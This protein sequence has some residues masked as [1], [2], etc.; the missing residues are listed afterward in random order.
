MNDQHLD[1]ERKMARERKPGFLSGAA[2]LLRLVGSCGPNWLRH[3][4]LPYRAAY[5]LGRHAP[6]YCGLYV[7]FRCNLSCPWCVNP[8]L[9][10]GLS[11]DDYEA[12]VA[13]VIRLLDHPLFRSVAHINLTGG[14]PLMNRH[15]PGI[16]RLIRQ[17]GFLVGMVTN[18]LLLEE[19]LTE[20]LDAGVADVRVSIYPNTVDRLAEIL[21]RLC[22]KLPIATSYIILKSELDE[23]PDAI[24]KVVRISMESGAVGSRLNFYMPTTEHGSKDIVYEDDPA[25]ADLKVR[26]ASRFPDYAVYWRPAVQRTIRGG[27]DKTCRQLWE[28]FHVDARGNLG[29]CCRYCFPDKERA[30][31]LFEQAVP[32]LLNSKQL[33]R[34]RAAL[35][36]PGSAIPA[37]CSQCLYL[38]SSKAAHKFVTSPLP[39]LIR[40][41]SALHRRR[42][43]RRGARPS[44]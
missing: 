23:Q 13:S 17:R 5:E 27:K 22:G 21:P 4:L 35:L 34:M 44:E 32:E 40:R 15:L 33:Q 12:D 37:E 41:S 11:L 18:G 2:G 31:N 24:E 42:A 3:Q 14:E 19:Q 29:L 16:I 7:T 39:S 30:G 38:S 28:N 8:S 25:L 10:A 20:L 36:D 1:S 43:D 6:M 26:L 9:P